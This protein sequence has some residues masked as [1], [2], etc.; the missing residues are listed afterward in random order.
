MIGPLSPT[1]NAPAPRPQFAVRCHDML[2]RRAAPCAVLLCMLAARTGPAAATEL[3]VQLRIAWGAGAEAPERWL[4]YVDFGGA[5]ATRLR[6]LGVEPDEAAA[7]RLEAGRLVIDPLTPRGF[8]GCDVDVEGDADEQVTFEIRKPR[9]V[10]P[11]VVRRTLGELAT[12]S[13]RE[14]LDE[15]GGFLLIRRTPGD[16][17]RIEHAEDSLVFGPD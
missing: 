5:K 10:S 2:R 1:L 3:D 11:V 16:E 4:G 8:D 9:S 7:L 14:P 12:G 15:F 17:L 13:L 6:P